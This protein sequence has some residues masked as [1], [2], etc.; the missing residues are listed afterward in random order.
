MAL[1][2]GSSLLSKKKRRG[3][4][5]PAADLPGQYRGKPRVAK[6]SRGL[7]CFLL[8]PFWAY[9]GP[10]R[11]HVEPSGPFWAYIGP[12]WAYVGL[13]WVHVGPMLGLC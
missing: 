3:A 8:F 4:A 9:V 2:Y 10:S 5:A 12:G 11:A 13:C 1:P 6:N 7:R